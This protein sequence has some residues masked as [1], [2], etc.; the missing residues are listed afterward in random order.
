VKID[1][2]VLTFDSK[3]V[4][5]HLNHIST[6]QG[7]LYLMNEL[8]KDPSGQFTSVKLYMLVSKEECLP[9]V[10]LLIFQKGKVTY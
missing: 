7:V 1:L 10:I 8:R 4:S 6:S 9:R 3:G 5:G 2:Q